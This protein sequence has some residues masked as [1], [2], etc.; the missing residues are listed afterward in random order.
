MC[1]TQPK[2]YTEMSDRNLL[3]RETLDG[4]TGIEV[5]A[6]LRKQADVFNLRVNVHTKLASALS[7]LETAERELNAAW[8]EIKRLQE[9]LH[10]A[11]LKKQNHISAVRRITK[12]G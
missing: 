3:L 7:L 5:P 2:G 6:I 8:A 9:Q 1:H 12:K 10:R 11:K 4:D